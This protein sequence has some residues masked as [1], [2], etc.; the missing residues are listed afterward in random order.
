MYAVAL[1]GNALKHYCLALQTSGS[2]AALR[3]LAF[4]RRDS[5][6]THESEYTRELFLCH[7]REGYNSLL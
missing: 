3:L 7:D 5:S 1:A 6:L 4:N 2:F